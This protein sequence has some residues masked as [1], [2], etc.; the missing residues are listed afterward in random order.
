MAKKKSP[1][2]D[3]PR[4]RRERRFEPRPTTRP[5]VAYAVGAVGAIGMG[6]GSWGELGQSLVASSVEPLSSGSSAARCGASRGT[7]SNA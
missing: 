7:V 3:K 2:R 4:A 6:A 1:K 5:W